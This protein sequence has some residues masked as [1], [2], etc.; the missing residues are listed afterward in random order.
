M[1]EITII[2]AVVFIIAQLGAFL[3]K[4]SSYSYRAQKWHNASNGALKW[5]IIT[6]VASTII[7]IL[8][9]SIA[10]LL[11]GSFYDWFEDGDSNFHHE[12]KIA[13]YLTIAAAVIYKIK[14]NKW[15]DLFKNILF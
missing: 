8:G 15:E 6:G 10:D 2:S 14:G 1:H 7:S 11:G 3:V 5:V 12:F 13:F 9:G 4:L